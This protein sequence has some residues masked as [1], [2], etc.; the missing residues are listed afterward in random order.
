MSRVLIDTRC[1]QA[2]THFGR[3]GT[4]K[5][6]SFRERAAH[7]CG[8]RLKPLFKL[9]EQITGFV[10]EPTP[11]HPGEL[12]R[13][14]LQDTT[15]LILTTRV[16]MFS[17]EEIRDIVA[18]TNEGGSLL[19]MS[20]HPPFDERDDQLAR[21]L[22]FRFLS[23]SYPWHM[24]QA[25]VT[26]IRGPD[27]GDHEISG[28]LDQG[29]V[30]NNSCRIAPPD[31]GEALVL[32]RLPGEPPPANVFA[33]VMELPQNGTRAGRVVAVADSGFIA[34]VATHVPGPG[35]FERGN[36]S[37]FLAGILAWL[38]RQATT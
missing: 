13:S 27:L 2:E 12:K 21:A 18:F 9:I 16:F 33:M 29:I 23:P 32:A 11:G 30:F 3:T 22:G 28:H 25:G 4:W 14:L 5:G 15:C 24:G 10:P 7:A 35:Q 34:P 1:L 38:C 20:N 17:Q 8:E 6:D 36:N 37:N 26:T 31:S 19:V